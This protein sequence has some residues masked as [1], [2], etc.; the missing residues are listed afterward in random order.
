MKCRLGIRDKAVAEIQEAFN[1]Y[2]NQQTG[3]GNKFI[4][5]LENYFEVIHKTPKTFK[6]SYKV[7]RE[8]PLKIFPFIVVYF[9]DEIEKIIVVASVFH[10]S[11]NPEDKFD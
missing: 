5:E 11:R 3:L 8:I 6:R 10:T 9:I 1:W 2:Q 7:Y 4:S